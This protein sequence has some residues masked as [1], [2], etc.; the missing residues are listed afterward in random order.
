MLNIGDF[1]WR[2]SAVY[3]FSGPDLDLDTE[4]MHH[5]FL[6]SRGVVPS[7]W[8]K[9]E[10]ELTPY[11]SE[12]SYANGISLNMDN[13]LI[14]ATHEGDLE[15]GKKCEPVELMIRYL[16]SVEKDTLGGTIM[17]WVLVA[18]HQNPGEWLGERLVRPEIV[19]NK[20]DEIRPQITFHIDV[21]GRS[22][23]FTFSA[24]SM[25][26]DA[27]E[28][29]EGVSIVCGIRQGALEDNEELIKWLSRWR[30]HERFMLGILESLLGVQND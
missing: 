28:A 13:G 14:R 20:W 16:H 1:K 17:R 8:E 19:Q 26:D 6:V 21:R 5:G 25:E 18:P 24:Y 4:N 7:D 30:E 2:E 27:G 3:V 11:Y 10:S 23:S 15:F 29:Q 22:M 9:N 12:I